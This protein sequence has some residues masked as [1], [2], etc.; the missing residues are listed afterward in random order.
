MPKKIKLNLK[1]LSIWTISTTVIV[2]GI[3]IFARLSLKLRHFP[4]FFEHLYWGIIL[5]IFT[6]IMLYMSEKAER[7]IGSKLM[8]IGLGLILSD[9]I[10]HAIFGIPFVLRP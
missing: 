9:L 8:G 3:T 1:E 2:L 6:F 4:F 7:K 10:H 5:I